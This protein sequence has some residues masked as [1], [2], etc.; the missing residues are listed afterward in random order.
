MK[1]FKKIAIIGVGLMGGSL[2][3]TLKQ[4]AIG[5][6]IWG[7]ARNEKTYKKLIQ[8]KVVDK[9]EK[10]LQLVVDDADVVIIGAPVYAII[11]YCKKISS[12]LKPG[13]LIIDIGSTK[14]YIQ[15]QAKKYLPKSIYFVGC[16][17]LC[18][19]EKSGAEFSKGDIYNNAICFITALAKTPE[20][21]LA[22]K[23]W[24]AIGCRNIFI[25]AANHD[26]MLAYISHVPHLIA[27]SLAACISDKN[28]DFS[29]PSLKDMIRVAGSPANI[30]ADIFLSNKNNIIN[31]SSKFIETLKKLQTAISCGDRQLII[32]LIENAN[33]KQQRII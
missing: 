14:E 8:L 31:A 33:K 17:P 6:E 15:K 1:Q 3:L 25:S 16:H 29:G 13:A 18:G 27:F 2:A 7:F 24:Q 26:K 10:D 20:A 28:I 22:G 32:K 23:F 12:F 11:E 21:K 19:G 30:W 9:V 4:K 5:D